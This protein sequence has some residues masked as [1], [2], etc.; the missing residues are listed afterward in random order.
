MSS[1]CLCSLFFEISAF[2]GST[3]VVDK[4]R[5]AELG[6]A[7]G[8]EQYYGPPLFPYV[9]PMSVYVFSFMFVSIF[10]II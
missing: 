2:G 3:A 6:D 8:L 10:G 9:L 4:A 7:A 5:L 1:R